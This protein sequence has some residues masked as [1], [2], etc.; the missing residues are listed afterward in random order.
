MKIYR[1]TKTDGLRQLF[2]KD[3]TFPSVMPLYQSLGLIGH[4][5]LDFIAMC[6]DP[7]VKHGGQCEEV[8]CNVIGTGD[9]TVTYVQKDDD[10]GWGI[11]A[12]DE[13]WNKFLWWHFDI[14]NPI[15]FVGNKLKFGDVLG[16]S[17]DTG[18]ST[19]AHVHFGW[20]KYGEDYNNGYHGASD[21][22]LFYDNRFC[23]DIK[24][25]IGIIQKM[26]EFIMAVIN[27]FKK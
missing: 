10:K 1:P 19:G 20:Y 5:G 18:Y 22:M 3:N 9:L 2:G 24:T 13:Q 25:Q 23:L 17:G 14:I 27:T 4:D 6:K 15:I 21:P 12:Q 7:Q 26:I 11:V 16:T 8:Y